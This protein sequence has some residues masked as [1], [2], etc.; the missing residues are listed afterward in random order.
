MKQVKTGKPSMTA[1][2]QQHDAEDIASRLNGGGFRAT[3]RYQ[4]LNLDALERHGTVEVRLHQGTLNGVKAIAWSQFIAGLIKISVQGVNLNL[5]SNLNPWADPR[6]RDAESC[7]NLLD[8]LVNFNC[9][10]A[11]TGDW[12]KNRARA[13]K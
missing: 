11:S 6:S 5:N 8:T 13:L 9:L 1:Q 2:W 12:L 3:S 7:V 4:S 10:N